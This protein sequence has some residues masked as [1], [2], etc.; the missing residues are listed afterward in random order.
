M[1]IVGTRLSGYQHRGSRTRAVLR[2]VVISQDL[3]FLD[4]VDGRQN[5]NAA[6]GQFVVVIAI[7]QPVGA[8]GP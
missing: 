5:R 1:K 7:E 4:G 8:L 2:G 3:E 6:R